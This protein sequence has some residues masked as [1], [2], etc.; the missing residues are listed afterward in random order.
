MA[1]KK[2]TQ[3][4]WIWLGGVAASILVAIA[5]LSVQW[6]SAIDKTNVL[7]AEINEL[8]VEHRQDIARLDESNRNRRNQLADLEERIAVIEERTRP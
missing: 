6:Q 5:M 2:K 3:I 8:T 7:Q 1:A 4:P